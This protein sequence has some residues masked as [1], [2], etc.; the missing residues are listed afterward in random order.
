MKLIFPFDSST[1]QW[2]ALR[3]GDLLQAGLGRDLLD[4]HALAA[5]VP[6]D[7]LAVLDQDQRLRLEDRAQPPEAEDEVGDSHRQDRE[8]ASGED[9]AG[10]RVVALG[11]ALLDQVAEHDQEDEVERLQRGE[12]AAADHA[13]DDE[14]EEER[15]ERL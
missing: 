15:E 5:Q 4:G 7:R 2:T 12:L 11:H 8:R 1:A 10:E 13:R 3:R 9:E 14:D 6:V